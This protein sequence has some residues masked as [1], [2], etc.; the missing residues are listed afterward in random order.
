MPTNDFLPFSAGGGANVITQAVYASLAARTSGFT[1]GT[2]KSNEFNKVVRQSSQ[3]AYVVLQSVVDLAAYDALDDGNTTNLLAAYKASLRS[4]DR[5][6]WAGVATGTGNAW[7]CALTP[8]PL[9]YYAG[10]RVQLVTP[11]ANSAAVTVNVS[12]L[13][14]TG[15]KR[16]DGSDF[17]SGELGSGLLVTLVHDGGNFRLASASMRMASQSEVDA[18]TSFSLA[19]SPATLASAIQKDEFSFGSTVGGTANAWTISLTPAPVA[20]TT[21]FRIKLIPTQTN[22]GN[23]TIATNGGAAQPA[24]TQ[25]GGQFAAGEIVANV[26]ME[27]VWDGTSWRHVLPFT[28]LATQAETNAGSQIFPV[29]PYAAAASIQQNKWIYI[30]AVGGTANAWTGAATPNPPGIGAGTEF[31]LV[32]SA[33]NTSTTVTL[34]MN[35]SAAQPVKRADG[36]DP[37]VGE[38]PANAFVRVTYDGSSY[39]IMSPILR[40]ASQAEFD[41]AS[42]ILAASPSTA[43]NAGVRDLWAFTAT[44]GGTAN[45]L[46]ITPAAALGSMVDG[47]RYRI[48]PTANNTGAM[49]INGVALTKGAGQAMD[50]GDIISGIPFYVTYQSGGWRMASP[51]VSPARQPNFQEWNT[52]GSF[53]WTVPA[54]VNW[55]YAETVGAGGGGGGSYNAGAGG[56]GNGGAMT[57]GWLQVTPGASLSLTIGAGG[58]GGAIG[59]NGGNGG[60]TSLNGLHV[61]S[62]GG[63]GANGSNTA[64]STSTGSAAT[65][66]QATVIGATAGDGQ[67]ITSTWTK[68]GVGGA[69]PDGGS[70]TESKATSSANSQ[71]IGLSQTRN[72]A[73]GSGASSTGSSGGAA[74]AAGSPGRIRI[75]W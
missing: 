42:A 34:A 70:P 21:G 3:A 22:T 54:G 20:I 11:A 33:V 43:M 64:G 52:A 4:A 67:V 69:P 68:G 40:L 75:W 12:T 35:G 55:I 10:M 6:S 13:G 49:T 53:S 16:S 15:V 62:G 14:V 37:A 59:S 38:I 18:G 36:N 9:A 5:L 25:N 19:V 65:G 71:Q 2:A 72:G 29:S 26:F 47:V 23:V 1:A 57:E 63:G 58:A 27:F 51:I 17:A 7:V 39:R 24:K 74:G 41:A 31:L 60:T 48:V 32:T 66:G 46:T 73:G 28:R 56:G 44:T 50:A 8:A 45:A 30:G 61:V